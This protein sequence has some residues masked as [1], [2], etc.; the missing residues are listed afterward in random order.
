[1]LAWLPNARGAI[2]AA[3]AVPLAGQ[4]VSVGGS[5]TV[6]VTGV[7]GT[8]VGVALIEVVVAVGVLL[9]GVGV[10]PVAPCEPQA[11]SNT[12]IKQL[13]RLIE[14]RYSGFANI[15]FSFSAIYRAADQVVIK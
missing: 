7:A 5:G 3:R 9:A 6:V 4:L 13:A 2:I 11:A 1:M 10:V 15:R 14:S 12:T 8:F